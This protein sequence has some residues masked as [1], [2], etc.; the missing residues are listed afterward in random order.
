MN[1]WNNDIYMNLVYKNKEMFKELNVRKI[2][3]SSPH[4]LNAFKNRY[5]YDSEKNRPN[6][7]HIVETF[8]DLIKKKQLNPKYPFNKKVTYHDPCYLGR[9]CNIYDAPRDII[10]AIP[11]IKFVEMRLIRE[12]SHC[13]GGGGG[14]AWLETVKGQR[15]GDLR[16][17]EAIETGA[18]VIVT[19]CPYCVQ[20]LESSILGLEK[21]DDISVMTISELLLKSL[22]NEG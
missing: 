14:G 6:T 17:L 8:A 10:T 20:M 21:Q 18:E 15:L 5:T 11:E 4:C 2:I 3:T 22:K 16:V 7:V 12:K 1:R 13:C 19:A 9:Y